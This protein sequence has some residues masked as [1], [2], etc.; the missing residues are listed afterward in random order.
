MYVDKFVECLSEEPNWKK[1]SF[2][3]RPLTVTDLTIQQKDA[4]SRNWGGI[5]AYS[6]KRHDG[7]RRNAKR[8]SRNLSTYMLCLEAD[9]MERRVPL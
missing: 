4:D 1:S 2:I 9:I 5:P 3:M 8:K 7:L 6:L